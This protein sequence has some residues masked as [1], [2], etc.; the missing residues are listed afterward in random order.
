MPAGL[1]WSARGDALV[2]RVRLSPKSAA[3]R[4]EGIDHLSDATAVLKVRVRALPQDGEANEA[5]LRLL[6]KSLGIGTSMLH[7]ESGATARVKVV[8]IAGDAAAIEARLSALC[9]LASS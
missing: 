8:A 5:L 2:L 9:G 4:I 7:L 1:P 3:D 6:A